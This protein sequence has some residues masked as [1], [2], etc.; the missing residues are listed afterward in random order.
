MGPPAVNGT[1]VTLP[2]LLFREDLFETHGRI[3]IV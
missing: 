2:V 1:A 3:L